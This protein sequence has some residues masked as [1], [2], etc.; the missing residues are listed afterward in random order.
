VQVK[1]PTGRSRLSRGKLSLF[2]AADSSIITEFIGMLI[3]LT[4][5]I[6][7]MVDI[8]SSI[9][10]MTSHMLWHKNIYTITMKQTCIPFSVISTGSLGRSM[11][12]EAQEF[13]NLLFVYS[14]GGNFGDTG[15]ESLEEQLL[16]SHRFKTKHLPS[17]QSIL[18]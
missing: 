18:K 3:S 7:V 17:H 1:D 15:N 10:I 13:I 9:T 8:L 11:S 5:F 12:L 16:L 14:S 6:V 4:K 2:L